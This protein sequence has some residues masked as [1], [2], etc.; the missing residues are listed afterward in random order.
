MARRILIVDDDA[1]SRSGLETLLSSWGYEIES[2]P[3][4]EEALGKAV[5]FQPA[6]VVTDLVMPKL[7][8]IKLLQALR[9]EV[10][11]ASVIILTAHGTI[12]TA[13]CAVKDGA[14]DYLTK[15]VE[16]ARLR[17]LIDK[18]LE[19]WEALREV[20]L[21]RR[22]VK[23]LWGLGRLVGKSPAMQEIYRHIDLAGPTAAPVLIWGESGTGKEIVARTLHER[24]PRANGPFVAVNCAAI[25]ET[26]LE[27]EIFGHER[28]AFTGAFERRPGCFE[29]ASGGTLL[30]DEIA[31]MAPATQA[32]FLRILQEGSVRR[33][34]GK[35]EIGV[36]VR[37]L[38]AT[39]QEP[40]RAVKAG[41]FREDLFYRLNVFSIVIP[42]L[43]ER[44]E[45]IPLLIDAFLEEFNARYQREVKSVDEDARCLL[46]AHPWPGN[47]RELRNVIE[48][49]VVVCEG[50][51]LT[52]RHLPRELAGPAPTAAAGLVDLPTGIS[53]DE[54][55]KRLILRTL[56]STRGNK[57]RAAEVLGISV[58]TL[59]NKL[60][61][62]RT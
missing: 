49:A 29:L 13:V 23:D 26:L 58:R 46:L 21:L 44:P 53:L 60:H 19:R 56:E 14:Y 41:R 42:P 30:L 22:R 39:N 37:V 2:A 55:E 3:D 24:S 6:V 25:P 36:D 11:T 12:E 32:K 48:R 7:D 27:S 40:L 50:D 52:A 5:A 17:L 47:A 57:T 9:L 8:G 33:L 31:E 62:Y 16:L 34:G 59:H 51:L 20:A 10:P 1:A 43:R 61:R 18:A 15:P 54:A 35:A 38:A 4:G 28:G 45:D